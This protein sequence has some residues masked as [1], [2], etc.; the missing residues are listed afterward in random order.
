MGWGER[1]NEPFINHTNPHLTSSPPP[2]RPET[3]FLFRRPENCSASC[4]L[5]TERSPLRSSG[6]RYVN[7][8]EKGDCLRQI[9]RGHN[10]YGLHLP[11]PHA[12]QP[13]APAN[14]QSCPDR[15][16]VRRRFR[17][18]RRSRRAR[19]MP[20]NPPKPPRPPPLPRLRRYPPRWPPWRGRPWFQR[21]TLAR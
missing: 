5:R 13:N 3:C 1:S 7:T 11:T 18:V 15:A 17:L 10:P 4:R 20:P 8:E 6:R 16:Y 2:Y 19:R 12:H 9:R 14:P 21:N